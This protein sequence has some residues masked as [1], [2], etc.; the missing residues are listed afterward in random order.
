ML[1]SEANASERLGAVVVL[2]EAKD[3][4]TELKVIWIDQGYCGEN[5]A[6]AVQQVCGKKVGV[7]VLPREDQRN[8]KLYR[9]DG[10]SNVHLGGSTDFGV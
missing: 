3:Q 7:E 4:L 1:V 2:H 9:N 5:F 10:S 8:L 6:R